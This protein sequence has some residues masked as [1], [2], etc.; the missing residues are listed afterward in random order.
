M[1]QLFI[2]TVTYEKQ[3]HGHDEITTHLIV[4]PV[5]ATNPSHAEAKVEHHIE[6]KTSN[7]SVYYTVVSIELEA[8]I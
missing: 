6:S 5:R 7:Y 8:E 1:E 3:L 2:A 4:V